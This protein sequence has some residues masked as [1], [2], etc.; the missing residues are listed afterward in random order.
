MQI[1]ADMATRAPPG[2][3]HS[4]QVTA[5]FSLGNMA[6]HAA[7]I[8]EMRRLE[9]EPPVLKM[10]SSPSGEVVR[11]AQRLV[12]KLR[13]HA[14][15]AANGAAVAGYSGGAGAPAAQGSGAAAVTQGM[16]R[17]AVQ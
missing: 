8:A 2:P 10:L 5:L 9:L 14:G 17:M 13:A 4:V 11:N 7:M 12:N 6:N 3:M 1:V 16:Q 15:A